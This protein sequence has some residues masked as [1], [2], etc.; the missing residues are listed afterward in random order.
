[1]VSL[2]VT[3]WYHLTIIDYNSYRTIS[4]SRCL[5][6]ML[7]V[8]CDLIIHGEYIMF[9]KANKNTLSPSMILESNSIID[10]IISIWISKEMKSIKTASKLS[11]LIVINLKILVQNVVDG[12]LMRDYMMTQSTDTD[13]IMSRI[14]DLYIYINLHVPTEILEYKKAS[15]SA[16]LTDITIKSMSDTN[17]ISNIAWLLFEIQHALRYHT[18]PK[19]T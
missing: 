14:Q 1:M 19:I 18:Q 10:D 12:E 4:M 5:L 9:T 7:I 15:M 16:A 2:I 6:L 17:G 8:R 11:E 13:F 3:V